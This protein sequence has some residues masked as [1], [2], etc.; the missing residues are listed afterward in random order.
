MWFAW[1]PEAVWIDADTE[2]KSYPQR[3]ERK[4]NAAVAVVD[5]DPAVGRVQHVGMRGTATPEPFEESRANRFLRRYHGDD[6]SAWAD[7]FTGP[8]DEHRWRF[9][10]FDHDTVVAR[11]QSYRCSLDRDYFR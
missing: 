10:R 7:R 3:V 5:F 1:E 9:I 11:N 2:T 8:W 6:E 4:P